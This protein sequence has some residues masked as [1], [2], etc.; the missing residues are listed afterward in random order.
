MKDFL[1]GLYKK[2]SSSDLLMRAAHT[3][4]QAFVAAL[5][6]SVV[7]VHDLSSAKAAL[8]AAVAAG[9]SALKT[10]FIQKRA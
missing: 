1:I 4:L 10:A 6:V 2:A 7:A 8:L 3:F 9:I 5:L